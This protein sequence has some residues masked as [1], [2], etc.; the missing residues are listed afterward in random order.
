MGCEKVEEEAEMGRLFAQIVK[1]HAL[2][3][4][5]MG[6]YGNPGPRT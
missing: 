3:F 5:R 2:G 1:K 6:R 4:S